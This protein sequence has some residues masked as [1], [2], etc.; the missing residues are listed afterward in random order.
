MTPRL[1]LI[2]LGI[3]A[4]LGVAEGGVRIVALFAPRV[5]FL[6]TGRPT[7]PIGRYATLE[8]FIAAQAAHIRPH[9]PWYNY[10]SNAFGFHDEEFVEPKPGGRRR[11]VAVGD[12]F[13]FG[14]VSYPQAVMTLTE[15]GLR[16][17]C[18]GRDLDLL[19]MGVMG[20]GPPEYRILVELGAPRFSPD[21]VL[22]N[23]FIGNDGPDLHRQVHDRSPAERALRHSY[24]WTLGKNVMRAR[25]GLRA[26]VGPTRAT[27]AP[28]GMPVAPGGT[29][30][31][32]DRTLGADDPLLVG[33]ILTDAAFHEVLASDLGRLYRPADSQALRVAWEPVFTDLDALHRA[34]TAAGSHV[35]LALFPSELQVDAGVLD[36][37]VA[38]IATWLR[39]RGLSRADIEPLLPNQQL[40]EFARTRDIPLIDLTPAF[41]AE[42]ATGSPEPL[43]KRNDNHWTPRG[44]RVAAR[45]LTA[46]LAPLVCGR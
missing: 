30:V 15:A 41:V 40:A 31:D 18:G 29:A 34:A 24:V 21:L 39:Y 38:R 5:H 27:G 17:T 3:L 16:A 6:A 9:Q 26:A 45:V 25:G 2:V 1:G 35:A 7:R 13:T 8:E 33:P 46:F 23:F 14:P 42:A 10:W 32:P 44:N 28:I 43:Y 4:A 20:A 37:T 11:V 12:S 36:A 22:V 19:N